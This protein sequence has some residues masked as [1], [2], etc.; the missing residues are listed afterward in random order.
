MVQEVL[1][2]EVCPRVG[3]RQG[4][5]RLGPCET[6]QESPGSLA[7]ALSGKKGRVVSGQAVLPSWGL[8]L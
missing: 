1:L 2:E 5:L 6:S 7:L 8:W 4:S 3:P